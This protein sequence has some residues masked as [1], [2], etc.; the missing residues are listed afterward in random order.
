VRYALRPLET[1]AGRCIAL[2]Q[3]ETEGEPPRLYVLF[4]S[5]YE[6]MPAARWVPVGQVFGEQEA[7]RWSQEGFRN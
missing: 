3:V 2:K 5:R 1:P 6:R 4:L 7:A